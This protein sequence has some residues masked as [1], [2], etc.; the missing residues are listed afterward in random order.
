M[1]SVEPGSGVSRRRVALVTGAGRGIGRGIALALAERGWAVV[2]NY[3]GNAT[4]AQETAA[5]VEAAGSEALLAQADIAQAADRQRLVDET[6]ERFGRID[7]LVNNAGMAPRQRMDILETTEES[8]DEVMAVN[9]KGPY[10]LTQQV[11]NTMI[12]LIQEGV[13]Q[14]PL[15]INIG[16]LSAYAASTNRGEYCISKAGLAMVTALFADRLA[17][18]GIHVYEVRPGIIET[19]MTSAVK[20][21]YDRLFEGGLTPIRRWGEPEDVGRAVAAIAEGY[22]PYS[23]GEVFNVDGGFHLRRL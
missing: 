18:Y 17:E 20:E 14:Q 19:D 9:L 3:R 16:S 6:L 8:Y 4:A 11:A 7:L 13:I 12:R 23:T 15:I 22:F 10:F 2:V 5:G 1:N 21:R